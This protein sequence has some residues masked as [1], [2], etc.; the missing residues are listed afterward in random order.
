MPDENTTPE[1]STPVKADIN[2]GFYA[3]YSNHGC[4]CTECRD[5]HTA[6]QRNYRNSEKGRKRTSA[7]NR[8]SRRTQQ[9]CTQY[10]KVN[11]PEINAMIQLQAKNEANQ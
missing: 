3:T 9:L 2:H 8:K 6:W 4:R 1:M 7:A 11:F 5:A 10:L